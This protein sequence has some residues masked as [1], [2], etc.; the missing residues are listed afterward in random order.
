MLAAHPLTADYRP[1]LPYSSGAFKGLS[2]AE[3]PI[4]VAARVT[5]V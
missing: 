1:G 5:K 3:R 2:S 4:Q